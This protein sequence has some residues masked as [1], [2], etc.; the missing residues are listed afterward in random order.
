MPFYFLIADGCIYIAYIGKITLSPETYDGHKG[1]YSD[2]NQR[3]GCPVRVISPNFSVAFTCHNCS[4]YSIT[5]LLL[6]QCHCL[7]VFD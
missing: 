4:E 5:L 6:I 7:L 3:V 2:S 1:P